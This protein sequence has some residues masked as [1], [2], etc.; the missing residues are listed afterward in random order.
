NAQQVREDILDILTSYYKVSRKCF[1]DVIC[2]QVISYFL[3]ERDESPLKIFRPELVMGLDD[4]Q[5]KTITGENKK[6]KRQQSMLESE[7]KNLKAAMKV[8]RS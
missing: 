7:I 6:T 1:V 8:L 4:E 2:K 3:L 5:L